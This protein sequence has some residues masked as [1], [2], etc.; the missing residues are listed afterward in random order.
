MKRRCALVVGTRP[1]AIKVAPVYRA[2]LEQGVLEPVVISTGQHDDLLRDT[3]GSV[4][5]PMHHDLRVMEVGQ[6]PAGVFARVAERLPRVLRDVL[7]AAVLVQGD[8]TSALAAALIGYYAGISVGHVEAGLR[9]YDHGH[10]FPEE[11]NRQMIA[12]VCRWCFAPTEAARQN[13]S[14]ERIEAER[15]HVTGNTAIDSVIWAVG[16]AEASAADEPYVLVTLH[17]RESFGEPLRE[18]LAGLR[19]F[20]DRRSDARA[21]WPMHPN[22]NVR[23]VAEEVLGG[24]QS[25]RITAPLGFVRFAALMA[26]AR[27]VLTDSGGIQEEAPSLGKRALV[28]RETTERPEAIESGQNWLVGRTADGVADALERAWSEPPYLGPVPAAS[29]YGDGH[30]GA[31]IAEIVARELC[32]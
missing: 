11:G 7:P 19:D 14:S 15:I 16:R 31:R 29:P 4:G 3:M 17:R 1:E 9:S 12:R 10:P 24:S 26:K 23:R 28:A 30:A 21:V 22:P 6:E 27:V 25:V 20:L 5:L 2:I 18:I 32:G 13:L 8:T